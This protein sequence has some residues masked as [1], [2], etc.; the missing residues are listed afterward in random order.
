MDRYFLLAGDQDGRVT[1]ILGLDTIKRL[2]GGVYEH[3][4]EAAK[5]SAKALAEYEQHKARS[6]KLVIVRGR[7]ALDLAKPIE[8]VVDSN[9]SF[10]V[11]AAYDSKN[12]YV[13]FDVTSPHDIVNA[14]AD[15]K[16]IFRGGNL[17]DIQIATDP[18]ADPNR[19]KPA[20]GDVRILISRQGEKAVA[21]VFRPKLKGFDGEPIVLKSPTGTESFDR[22]EP[23]DAVGLEYKR[24]QRKGTFTA[25]ATV[26]MDLL[27]WTAKPGG[28]VRMDL[29]Y[30]FGNEPGTQVATRA[31]WSNNSF[32]ANV[33]N[34][35][36]H[37]SRL[38]PDQWSTASLE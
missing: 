20:P 10:T 36:P 35:I 15:P 3:T 4:E 23:T 5:T 25:V 19:K 21:V 26:P 18:S 17:L 29:G 22:I 7:K 16:L 33:V 1:E 9:R 38:E 32:T 14:I 30:L 12:L 6:Q 27:G 31:Y 8:K 2:K 13:R 24:D 28:T 34:D 11:R 37:E